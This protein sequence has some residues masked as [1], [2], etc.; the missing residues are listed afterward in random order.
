MAD[1]FSVSNS[2]TLS[3]EK[4]AVLMTDTIPKK[5]STWGPNDQVMRVLWK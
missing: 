2:L 1:A 4:V 5:K 3:F